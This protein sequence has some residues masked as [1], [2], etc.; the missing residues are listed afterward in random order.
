MACC[1]CGNEVK[2]GWTVCHYCG[3]ELVPQCRVLEEYEIF[4]ENEYL[5][6][7]TEEE[8]NTA[9]DDVTMVERNIKTYL[10]KPVEL[11]KKIVILFPSLEEFK[12]SIYGIMP[13]ITSILLLSVVTIIFFVLKL[14]IAYFIFVWL[15]ETIGIASKTNKPAK[16]KII[17][18]FDITIFAICFFGVFNIYC[19][20]YIIETY[21]DLISYNSV[22]DYTHLSEI[23]NK[24]DDYVE[25]QTDENGNENIEDDISEDNV[26]EDDALEDDTTEE[27]IPEEDNSHEYYE[28]EETIPE[29]DN[30]YEYYEIEET[31]PEED[32]SYEYYEIEE[33]IPEVETLPCNMY[34]YINANG[35]TVSCYRDTYVLEG[36]N[37]DYVQQNLPDNTRVKAYLVCYSMSTRWYALYDVDNDD[38]CGWIDSKYINFDE[39]EYEQVQSFKFDGEVV[40]CYRQGC[41]NTY[42]K[43]VSGYKKSY[44]VDGGEIDTVRK[45]L[46]NGW[47][48]TSYRY[49]YSRNVLWYELYDTDDGDYYG[50]VDSSYIDFQ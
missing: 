27:T 13:Y 45:K 1:N 46:G 50:W 18:R 31:I 33:T 19:T 10:S 30:S 49:C 6:H 28:I 9:T 32:N 42:G 48:V 2:T 47:H 11:L 40:E 3:F 22:K 7:D 41:I 39:D 44:V 26:L 29:E 25:T 15:M 35:E 8:D 5:S 36:R 16:R 20:P 24:K 43:K 17:N 12:K 37:E 21:D 4:D 14:N 38:Y 34:G 23:D